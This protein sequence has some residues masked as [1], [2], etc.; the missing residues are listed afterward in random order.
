MLKTTVT[1]C[2]WHDSTALQCTV[3]FYFPFRLLV[4]LQLIAFIIQQ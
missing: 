3:T 1:Y 2:A 4:I